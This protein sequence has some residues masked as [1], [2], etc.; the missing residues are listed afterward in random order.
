MRRGGKQSDA[1]V[2]FLDATVSSGIAKLPGPGL[3][4]LCADFDGDG[5][6]DILA[7]NDAAANHLWI[8]Q[9]NGK[10]RE[11]AISR[12]VAFTGNGVPEGNMGVVFGDMNGD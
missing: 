8:N 6:P 10:F 11:E 3:G 9:K 5:W 7:A 1:S 2:R 4:V 12:G